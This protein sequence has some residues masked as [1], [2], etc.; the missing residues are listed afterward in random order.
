VKN[1]NNWKVELCQRDKEILLDLFYTKGL[2]LEILLL[3]HFKERHKSTAAKRLERLCDGHYLTKGAFIRKSKVQIVY[4][5]SSKGLDVIQDQLAGKLTRKELK[6]SNLEHDLTLARIFDRI[7]LARSLVEIKTENEIQS[8]NFGDFDFEYGPFRRLNTD[9]YFSF[10]NKE[11]EYKVAVEFERT[12]KNQSRWIK[13]LQN[14][15]LEDS[16]N[17]VLYICNDQSIINRLK[18]IESDL[19]RKFSEKIFFCTHDDFFSNKEFASF[20]NS[21]GKSFTV[22]FQS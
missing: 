12:K 22:N 20:S 2:D 6:S 16:V 15:H 18:K 7:S 1:K 4:T 14:Y 10:R 21:S 5:I 9:I 11:K 19:A 13:H 8:I 17:I 3:R